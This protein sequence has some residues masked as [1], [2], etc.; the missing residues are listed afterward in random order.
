M[1]EIAVALCVFWWAGSALAQSWVT[2][3]VTAAYDG[4]TITVEA[5]IWPDLTWSGSVRVLGVDAPEIQS[6]CEAERALA[7]AA[8]D[9]VRDLLIDE[10]VILGVIENEYGGRVLANVYIWQ[11]GDWPA[12]P[13]C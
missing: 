8:R 7:I 5:G 12:C 3:L 9:Y 6:A 1:K 11:D 10:S 13:T 2:A 4:D